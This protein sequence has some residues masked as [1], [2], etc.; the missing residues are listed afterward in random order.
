M[1][2]I[3]SCGIIV[4]EHKSVARR[5]R[6]MVRKVHVHHIE[7]WRLLGSRSRSAS[8]YSNPVVVRDQLSLR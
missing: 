8:S 4:L 1:N 3:F 6:G 7:S 2:V 5:A